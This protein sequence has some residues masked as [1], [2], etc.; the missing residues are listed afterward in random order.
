MTALTQ[1]DR[2]RLQGIAVKDRLGTRI[3]VTGLRTDPGGPL[4]DLALRGAQFDGDSFVQLRPPEARRLIRQ[5]HDA[6]GDGS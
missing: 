2:E 6:I 3:V 4:V 1:E 5:L